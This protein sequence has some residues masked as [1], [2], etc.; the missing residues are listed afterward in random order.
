MVCGGFTCSKNA[1]C[2]LNVV[3]MVSVQN[4]SSTLSVSQLALAQATQLLNV[5]AQRQLPIQL[6]R[7]LITNGFAFC[8]TCL[9]FHSADDYWYGLSLVYYML[10][11]RTFVVYVSQVDRDLES[12]ILSLQLTSLSC[13]LSPLCVKKAPLA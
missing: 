3:Y 11:S 8:S 12:S 10:E 1:L 4:G 5:P 7:R 13:Q 9:C 6:Q 2:S